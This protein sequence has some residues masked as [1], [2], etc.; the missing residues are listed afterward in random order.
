MCL[1]N[2]PRRSEKVYYHGDK[3]SLGCVDWIHGWSEAGTSC[4]HGGSRLL[5]WESRSKLE[6]PD[7]GTPR[8]TQ[9]RLRMEVLVNSRTNFLW[10][11]ET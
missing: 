6:I 4:F 9:G 5:C 11:V 3:G 1:E 2:R 7:K 10:R 8:K